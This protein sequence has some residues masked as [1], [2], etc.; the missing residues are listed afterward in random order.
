MPEPDPQPDEQPEQ[1]QEHAGRL[2]VGEGVQIVGQIRDC[3]QIEIFGTVDGD[4]EVEDL[5]V[6]ENGVLKGNIKAE[7]AEVWGTLD[8]EVSVKELLDVKAGGSVSGKTE[9]GALSIAT[10]AR[11]IGTLDDG[12]NKLGKP[13]TVSTFTPSAVTD[14]LSSGA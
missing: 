11:V 8:G 6:H 4:L 3:R 5:V 2:V 1:A 12:S 9:Y 13:A 10:G 7:R 14:R